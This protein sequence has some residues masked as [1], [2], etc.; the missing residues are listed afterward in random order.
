MGGGHGG[1]KRGIKVFVKIPKKIL[2]FFL[3]GGRVR[4][5]VGLVGGGSGSWGGSGWM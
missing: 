1:C 3:G 2:F 5:G 4:G